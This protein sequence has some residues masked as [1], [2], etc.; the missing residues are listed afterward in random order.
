MPRSRIAAPFT[1]QEWPDVCLIHTGRPRCAVERRRIGV[2][3]AGVHL[4]VA[5]GDDP[6]ARLLPGR[7]SLDARVHVVEPGARRKIDLEE[8]VA[9]PDRVRVCVVETRQHGRAPEVDPVLRDEPVATVSEREDSAAED[10]QAVRDG[11]PLVLGEDSSV[12]DD[13]VYAHARIRILRVRGC[14][15]RRRR[16]TRVACGSTRRSCPSSRALRSARPRRRPSCRPLAR[17]RSRSTR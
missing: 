8:R 14:A 6:L 4:V 12:L 9:V 16:P 11:S 17:A 15:D 10:G 3:A 5:G 2:F 7:G 13:G 1:M